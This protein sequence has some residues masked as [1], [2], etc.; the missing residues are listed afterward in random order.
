MPVSAPHPTVAPS[1]AQ[2]KGRGWGMLQFL[3]SPQVLPSLAHD[4]LQ[5]LRKFLHICLQVS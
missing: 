4:V 2:E 5:P 1:L 3:G